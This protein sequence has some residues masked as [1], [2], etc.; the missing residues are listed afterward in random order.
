MSLCSP[1]L[2]MDA[3]Y[4]LC[5]YV[6][7]TLHDILFHG[8]VSGIQHIPREGGLIIAANHASFLDPPLIGCHVPR[9][10]VFFARKTLWKGG[11]INW[12]LDIVGTIPIDRDSGADVAAI[13]R[14]LKALKDGKALIVFPEGTRTRTGALQRPKA[15]VGLLACRSGVPVVP[16]R[17]FGSFEAFGRKG[18]LRPGTPVSVIFGPALRP[19]D[20]DDRADGKERFQL[21][22]ERIMTAIAA[23]NLPRP[24]VI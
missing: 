20:Y 10:L 22:S 15:G 16:A 3:I 17:I 1:P 7:G 13:K 4:G 5:Y 18:P 24:Q 9:Q 14:V 2:K 11:L 6:V 23:L 19:A 8:D 21:A 12:W